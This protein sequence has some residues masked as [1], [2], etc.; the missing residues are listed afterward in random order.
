[1]FA[2]TDTS[3]QCAFIT[4]GIKSEKIS[5]GALAGSTLALNNRHVGTKSAPVSIRWGLCTI[6]S[7]NPPL[8]HHPPPSPSVNH[9]PIVECVVFSQS[10]ELKTF[11]L[12]ANAC[13]EQ[14]WR[15]LCLPQF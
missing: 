15:S 12:G 4:N 3:P 13:G 2:A 6:L 11:D 5:L 9:E 7:E 10:C 14:G 8:L 1:M